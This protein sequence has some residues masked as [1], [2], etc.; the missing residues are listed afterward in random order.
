MRACAH[1]V[2]RTAT[3]R[4][5]VSRC[6][7]SLVAADARWISPEK[8]LR[9]VLN[10]LST[11]VESWRADHMLKRAKAAASASTVSFVKRKGNDPSAR[12]RAQINVDAFCSESTFCVVNETNC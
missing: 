5:V 8:S 10:A 2:P 7:H 12:E 1:A 9:P 6:F 4:F 3:L 11:E